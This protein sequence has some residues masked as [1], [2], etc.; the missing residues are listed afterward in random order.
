MGQHASAVLDDGQCC[1]N[2]F[3]Q[4][5][6]GDGRKNGIVC[7]QPEYLQR[8]PGERFGRANRAAHGNDQAYVHRANLFRMF[9]VW[10]RTYV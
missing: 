7:S 8:G 1:L 4:R 6:D 2:T 3:R 9:C 5:A 10:L